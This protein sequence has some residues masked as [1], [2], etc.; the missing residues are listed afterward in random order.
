MSLDE[1]NNFV[2]STFCRD[3][4]RLLLGARLALAAQFSDLI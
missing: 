1:F 2:M 4:R 3:G